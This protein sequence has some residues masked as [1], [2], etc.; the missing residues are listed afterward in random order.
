MR[1]STSK[2]KPL[3]KA[4]YGLLILCSLQASGVSAGDLWR[5][6]GNVF[7]N[8][9]TSQSTC[10]RFKGS[11]VC[12]SGLNRYYT[13]ERNGLTP[14]DATCQPAAPAAS[15]FVNAAALDSNPDGSLNWERKLEATLAKAPSRD[16]LSG[17]LDQELKQISDLLPMIPGG[18]SVLK[19][20][21][22]QE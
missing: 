16:S 7:T 12:G 5:C 21:E 6:E 14:E 11:R 15:P 8:R 9:P 10:R 13:P 22:S 1:E 17:E 3:R 19:M 20:L 2:F 18:S 4:I